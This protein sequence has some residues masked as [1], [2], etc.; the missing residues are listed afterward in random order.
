MASVEEHDERTVYLGR[1]R[2]GIDAT[3]AKHLEAIDLIEA[4]PGATCLND[5][6]TEFTP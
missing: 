1:K 5:L 2:D 4:T 3:I 6:E